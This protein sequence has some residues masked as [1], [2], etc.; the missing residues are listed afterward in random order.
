MV[1]DIPTRTRGS[2]SALIAG[3]GAIAAVVA[4]ALVIG[5]TPDEQRPARQG[6]AASRWESLARA[7]AAPWPRLQEPSGRLVDYTDELP[8]AFGVHGGTRYGD[9]VM[10]YALIDA[11]VRERDRRLVRTGIRAISFATDPARR[12]SRPSVFE[13][14]AVAAAYNIARESLADEPDF[15]RRRKRWEAWLRRVRIVELQHVN[16]YY[17]HWLVDAVAILELQRTGLRSGARSAALGG[18]ARRARRLA[19]ELV[20]V[21]IPSLLPAR[22]PAVLSD[23]PDNPLAY[24]GLSLGLYARAVHL[25]GRDAA[26]AARRVLQ[27][28]VWAAALTM[29]PNG[30]LAYVGRSQEEVWAPA[31][32]A[33]AA[34]FT[35]GLHDSSSAVASAAATVS[36]RSLERLERAYPVRRGGVSIVPAVGPALRPGWRGLDRYAGAPSMGGLALMLLNWTLE[37]H[38]PE[39]AAGRLPA[40]FRLARAVSQ[41]RGRLAVVRRGPT[42][43]AVKVSRSGSD[44]YR[45]DLRYDAGLAFAMRREGGRWRELVP[46]RP[47]TELAGRASAGPILLN[48]GPGYFFGHDLRVGSD[49][50]VRVDGEFRDWVGSLRAV[51]FVYRPVRCGVALELDAL[52][53]DAY[54]LSVFFSRRPRLLRLGATDGRQT[55]SIDADRATLELAPG[56]MASGERARLWRVDMDIGAQVARRLSVRFCAL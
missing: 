3:G 31:G 2:R 40:D 12:P 26:P 52:A 34:A 18:G 41:G 23:A 20:N 35:A 56:T 37:L 28:G 7:M 39:R 43:F 14:L 33:Y 9:A 15:R 6:A 11:G 24:H 25:M 44:R 47:R 55:V 27:Q 50:T 19:E 30:S 53:G 45:G 29:A 32:A 10:G 13:Q 17:N 49:G 5:A 22:G 36:H 4:A 48:G 46:Q 42:W 38:P 51:S 8:G 54:R 16:R 21:R 1:R